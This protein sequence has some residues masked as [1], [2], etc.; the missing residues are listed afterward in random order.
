MA[1]RQLS[2]DATNNDTTLLKNLNAFGYDEAAEEI[3]GCTYPEW[4]KKTCQKSN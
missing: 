3:Y 4:K 1:A 2:K